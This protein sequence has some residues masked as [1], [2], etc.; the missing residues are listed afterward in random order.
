[1]ST[2][3]SR[4][5]GLAV[6]RER[7]T[8]LPAIIR[9]ALR[10]PLEL[11]RL[12]GV[13]GV[14]TTGVG[15]SLAHARYLAWLLRERAGTPAW[16][17]PSGAWVAPPGMA[18][19]DQALVV[20]SQGLSPNARFPLAH[21]ERY[22]LAVL[23]TAAHED[24][25]DRAAAVRAARDRGVIVVPLG[26]A[27]EYEVL[28]RIVGPMVGYAVGLRLANAAGAGIDVLP[29][30]VAAAIGDAT[31]RM[32]TSLAK[33]GSGV[34]ADPITLV[35]TH[36]SAALF[37]NLAAKVQEGMYLAWPTVV[38][39][40]ELAHGALQE[41][42]GKPR[43]FLA[44]TCG[45]LH[46]AELLA[47]ARVSLEPQHRWLEARA[48][49]PGPLAIFEQEAMMNAL[50]LAAITERELDQREWPGKGRDGSLYAI[51]STADLERPLAS[52]AP[53]V[54][55]KEE[56]LSRLTWQELERQ[57]TDGARTVVV[58]LGATEQHGPHLPLD[59]DTLVADALADRFC[60]RVPEAVWAPTLAIGCSSE[61]LAFAGTLSL[62]RATLGA[63][64]SDI[65][66]SLVQHGFDHVV[67]FSAHGGNDVALAEVE[68]LLRARA[69]PAALTVV[70]GID[71]VA[72]AW[73]AASAREGVHARASGHH[74]GE[75]ETSIVAALRP[76]AVRWSEVRR[77]AEV[78][79]PDSQ[80]LFYPSLRMNAPDGVVGDPCE[81]SAERAER[82]LA[83]WT[84]V[85][86]EEYRE[87]KRTALSG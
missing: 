62:S 14:V 30:V 69:A 12:D 1:M 68:S 47:R 38:D 21:A 19:G 52:P 84:D 28:L 9:E 6:L 20:F 65:V 67:V 25:P 82:Y 8:R 58:P 53:A 4:A 50:V 22:R 59:V 64:L 70:H 75:Y 40:L 10:V 33:A 3:T 63:V 71:R 56:R 45:A 37:H 17:V 27:R 13:R 26:C 76:E 31:A 42:S 44:L 66:S 24:S 72:R 36:G 77:G 16:D 51:G 41:A 35:G 86:V 79:T 18:A 23:V 29:E 83:A 7:Q 11:P 32:E 55:R 60:A 49:L 39:V 46:E 85:L 80:R 57:I 87:T 81:A 43:T 78:D 54:F 2:L 34:L 73:Q 61:H 74:A 15:S 48:L 5:E